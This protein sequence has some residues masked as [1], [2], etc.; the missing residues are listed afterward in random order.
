MGA[1]IVG[2]TAAVLPKGD[3][4]KPDDEWELCAV[5]EAPAPKPERGSS[6]WQG[7]IP[8]TFALGVNGDTYIDGDL[9]LNGRK[10]ELR[11]A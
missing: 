10:I 8:Y 9:Y 3:A 5:G 11:R 6:V 4:P 1:A 2:A 7:T